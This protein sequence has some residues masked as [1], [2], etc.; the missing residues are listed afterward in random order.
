MSSVVKKITIPT[1]EGEITVLPGH[2]ALMSVLGL[3]SIEVEVDNASTK[4]L[5]FVDGGILQVSN[6]QVELLANLAED[7]K[8]LDEAK[9]EEARRRAE[10]LLE[11][12]PVDTDFA[13]VEASLQREIARL[14]VA[15]RRRVARE[16]GLQ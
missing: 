2:V 14:Q 13:R 8:E 16:S 15:R 4:E 12:R 5:F 1:L 6:D 10:K 7:A 3:G 9:I 11:E